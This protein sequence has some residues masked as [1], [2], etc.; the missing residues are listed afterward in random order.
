MSSNFL[1]VRE[2]IVALKDKLVASNCSCNAQDISNAV[3]CIRLRSLIKNLKAI[4]YALQYKPDNIQIVL[5]FHR[6][7][8]QVFTANRMCIHAVKGVFMLT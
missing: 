5:A 6:E 4:K 7:K 1:E 8:M 3:F 2:I